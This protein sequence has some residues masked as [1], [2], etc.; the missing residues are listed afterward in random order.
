MKLYLQVTEA[1]NAIQHLFRPTRRRLRQDG[2]VRGPFGPST[3]EHAHKSFSVQ[4]TFPDTCL[5]S[6]DRTTAGT[7]AVIKG[8]K[9]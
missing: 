7:R 1:A 9:Q 3:A 2:G 5:V 6:D 8:K 4:I